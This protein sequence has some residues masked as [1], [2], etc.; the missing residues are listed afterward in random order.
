MVTPQITDHAAAFDWLRLAPRTL[1]LTAFI[2]CD[3]AAFSIIGLSDS[4]FR[5]LRPQDAV[6]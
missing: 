5:W 4:A 2:L 6:I 3:K 1:A